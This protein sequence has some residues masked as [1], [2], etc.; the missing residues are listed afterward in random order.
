MLNRLNNIEY[1]YQMKLLYF[2]LYLLSFPIIAANKY[3]APAYNGQ[4]SMVWDRIPIQRVKERVY[5]FMINKHLENCFE[6]YENPSLLRL[7]CWTHNQLVDVTITIDS[8]KKS[9]YI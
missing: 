3:E 9:V 8:G 4:T 5:D 1:Y 2:F 6:F 7:K